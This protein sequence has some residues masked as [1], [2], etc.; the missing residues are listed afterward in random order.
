MILKIYSLFDSKLGAYMAPM[1]FHSRGQAIRSIVDE[2]GRVDSPLHNHPGDFTL[3]ELGDWNDSNSRF[4][5]LDTPH[6]CG[7]ISELLAPVS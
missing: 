6:S 4:I 2:A 7:V 1:Y 3:F 5:P